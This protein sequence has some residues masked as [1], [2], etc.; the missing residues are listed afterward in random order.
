MPNI[1]TIIIQDAVGSDQPLRAGQGS[2]LTTIENDMGSLALYSGSFDL[3]GSNLIIGRPVN[4]RQ[5]VGPYTN[6][7]TLADECEMDMILS[8]GYVLN[9]STIRVFWNCSP[10]GGPVKGNMKFNY[11]VST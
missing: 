4:V 7:G 9:P 8:T 1:E 11:Y 3:S 2:H 6:K 10:K 5:A